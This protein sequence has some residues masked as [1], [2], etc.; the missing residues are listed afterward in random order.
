[1]LLTQIQHDRAILDFGVLTNIARGSQSE[2]YDWIKIQFSAKVQD[3]PTFIAP[4][5]YWVSA[6][7]QYNNAANIWVGQASF[8]A[9]D[10]NLV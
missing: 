7:V 1:M 9:T 2:D 3:H 4:S 5:V 6:G 10:M 8:V